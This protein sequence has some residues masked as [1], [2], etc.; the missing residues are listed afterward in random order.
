VFSSFA[1]RFDLRVVSASTAEF[2]ANV[3]AAK[4]VKASNVRIV[5]APENWSES[6]QSVW[7]NSQTTQ[8]TAS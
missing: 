1:A 6:Y 7:R 3:P 2:S 5:S 8:L 4:I